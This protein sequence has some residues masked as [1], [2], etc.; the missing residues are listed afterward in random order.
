VVPLVDLV[1][2]VLGEVLLSLAYALDIGDPEG[3]ALLAR[4]VALRHNFGLMIRDTAGR[5]RSA[6][7]LPRQEARPG[8]AWHVTGSLLGLDVA[9][10]SM[11][12]RRLNPDPVSDAP[13]LSAIERETVSIGVAL[14]DPRRLLDEDRDAIASAIARGR[15]RVLRLTEADFESVSVALSLDGRRSRAIRW[16]LAHE[17]GALPSMFS[18][19]ELLRLGGGAPGADL[20]AWGVAALTSSSCP[21]TH[22]VPPSEWPL[23][24]GRPQLGLMASAMSDLNLHVAV[25]LHDLSVPAGLAQP[26][27]EAAVQEFIESVAPTDPND[28]WTLARSAQAVPRERIE[29]YIASTAAVGGALVPYGDVSAS[30]EP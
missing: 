1:D 7:A 11:S 17:P 6:W 18:L 25:A 12:L 24:E 20:D 5:Q 26:V 28:W 2:V 14:M 9:L 30:L 16:M 15:Q 21:C 22:V 27:L 4:N 23:L 13:R 19:T 8:V 3:T 29:D 10:A